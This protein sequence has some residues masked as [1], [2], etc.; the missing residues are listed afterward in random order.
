M[1]RAA[2]IPK[3][4]ELLDEYCEKHKIPKRDRSYQVIKGKCYAVALVMAKM[5]GDGARAVYGKY[6]GTSVERSN[7]MFHRHGWVVHKDT[8]WDPTRWVFEGRRPHMWSGPEDS[9]EY[10]EGSWK[11]M[12]QPGLRVEQ[13]DRE[14][15]K[16]IF[17]DWADGLIPV[18][19]SE[20]FDDSR[21]CTHL[22]PMEVHYIVHVSPKNLGSHAIEVYKRVREL[23]FG[24]MIPIDN[25]SYA[26]ALPKPPRRKK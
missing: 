19:L 18:F 6:H 15:K 5:I 7:T 13:P 22:T 10:D 16:L 20:L 26:D 8:I 12:D 24:P 23:K 2:R 9:E 4:K 21:I 11:M 3:L 14:K 25:Q 17:M 1:P